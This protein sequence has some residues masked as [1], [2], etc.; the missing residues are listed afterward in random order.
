MEAR[1]TAAMDGRC[2][3]G[4]SIEARRSGRSGALRAPG[5]QR[6]TR[7]ASPRRACA[8]PGRPSP[9]WAAVGCGAFT[10]VWV[11][12]SVRN[13]RSPG[14]DAVDG[15]PVFDS[16]SHVQHEA[17]ACHAAD[18]VEIGLDDLGDLCEQE[19]E[20]QDELA[21]RLAIVRSA[22][23]QP[24]QF[25]GDALGGVD[26]LVGFCV[27]R[28]WQA[29]RSRFGKAGLEPAQARPRSPSPDRGR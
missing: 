11:S 13:R 6:R 3:P 15:P 28:W 17:A 10:G 9:G 12:G 25:S 19:G 4:S 18:G 5:G 23:S 16:Q 21:Q 24:V 26:Q 1:V 7:A 27:R 8:A 29:K 2:P 14:L 20:A 22:A